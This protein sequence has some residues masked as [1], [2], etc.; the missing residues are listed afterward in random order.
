MR[1]PSLAAIS[2]EAKLLL[3]GIPVLLWTLVP[4]YHMVLFAVPLVLPLVYFMMKRLS[5]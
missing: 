4:V 1:R 3:I 2:A 5:K